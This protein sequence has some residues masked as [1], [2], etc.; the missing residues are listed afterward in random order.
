MP[1]K[2][3]CGVRHTSY[4]HT[5]TTY[6]L[7]D[8]RQYRMSAQRVVVVIVPRSTVLRRIITLHAPKVASAADSTQADKGGSQAHT[9]PSAQKRQ[10]SG[11]ARTMQRS[12]DALHSGSY[13]HTHQQ[14]YV[15]INALG[16]LQRSKKTKTSSA[17]ASRRASGSARATPTCGDGSRACVRPPSEGADRG[18]SVTQ[19]KGRH[20]Q[21]VIRR[22]VTAAE[23][24]IEPNF[25]AARTADSRR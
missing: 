3:V 12:I 6:Y 24:R 19:R 21:G 20:G 23:Q 13:I 7:R 4:I 14:R 2:L 5:H 17:P 11:R 8:I 16:C 10:P 18:E 25:Q 9:R 1:S 22:S 15:R